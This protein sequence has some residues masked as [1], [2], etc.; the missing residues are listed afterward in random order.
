ME[1]IEGSYTANGGYPKPAKG[2]S[3]RLVALITFVSISPKG[4]LDGKKAEC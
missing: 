2:D 4:R 1:D 3:R